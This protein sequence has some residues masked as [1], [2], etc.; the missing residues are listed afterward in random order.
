[1]FSGLPKY[2]TYR[3]AGGWV[4]DIPSS[5]GWEPARTV[6][7]ERRT[8]DHVDEP[9][10]SVTIGRGVIPQNDLLSSSAKKDSSNVDKSKYKLVEPGDL[11]YNKMR[12]WQGAAGASTHRGIVSPAYIVMTPRLDLA[13]YYHYVVRTPTFAKEAERWSY[14]ITSDQWSLRPEHFKMIRFPVPPRDEQAAIVRYLAHANTRIDKAITAKRRLVALLQ[15]QA[16]AQRRELFN[17]LVAPQRLASVIWEGPTNGTSPEVSENGDLQTFSISVVRD[18]VVDVRASDVK[19]VERSAV[20]DLARYRLRSEDILVVRGNGN[21]RLVGRAA[22]VTTDMP[23]SIFP[24]LLMRLRLRPGVDP[25]YI[26]AALNSQPVRE[27]IENKARTAVGTYKLN[28]AD[29]Q[30]LRVPVPDVQVQKTIVQELEEIDKTQFRVSE[31]LRKE[32]V[33]LQE[34]RSRIT[35]DVVTGQIDVRGIAATLPHPLG[36]ISD[37][38]SMPGDD[39]DDK[40]EG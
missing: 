33:L 2:D 9:M 39:S 5:W 11:V 21:L 20:R 38:G 16:S 34:F 40:G 10:L 15:E 27:Q 29:V 14:G 24:D 13:D 1:M 28:G 31:K 6:F 37:P 4:S 23:D 12:A 8:P 19:Y 30:G 35:T 7:V 26:V 36:T 25:R 32:I 17:G 22:L 3:A 18:G